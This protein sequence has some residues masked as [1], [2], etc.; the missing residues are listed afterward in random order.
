MKCKEQYESLKKNC[1]KFAEWLSKMEESAVE[2]D[3]KRAP[4]LEIKTLLR[5]L[6]KQAIKKTEY[7]FYLYFYLLLVFRFGTT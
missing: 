7:D 5:D 4:V 2:L 1:D 6:E 3:S